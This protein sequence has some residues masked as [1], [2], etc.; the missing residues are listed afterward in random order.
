MQHEKL[1]GERAA[2]LP[3]VDEQVSVEKRLTAAESVL[4][5]LS[6]ETMASDLTA[7]LASEEIEIERVSCDRV[8]DTVPQ[9]RTEGQTT[10]IP[11][12]EERAIVQRQLVL[13]EEIRLSRRRSEQTVTVPVELRRQ[14]AHVRRQPASP[15]DPKPTKPQE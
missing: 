14:H 7:Q 11:V 13:V 12:V 8:I 4:V 1:I 9:I 3:V 2:V 6:T 5:E 10:I 15:A